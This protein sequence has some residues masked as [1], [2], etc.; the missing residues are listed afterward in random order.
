MHDM[1]FS[2]VRSLA[3][4]YSSL[5]LSGARG[6]Q[7]GAQGC[8]KGALEGPRACFVMF[9]VSLTFEMESSKAASDNMLEQW[10]PDMVLIQ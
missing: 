3:L 6:R 8:Q 2:P 4:I 1:I 9:F 10:N 5:S 7:E